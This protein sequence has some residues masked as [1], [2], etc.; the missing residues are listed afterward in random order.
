ML[1]EFSSNGTFYFPVPILIALI[2]KTLLLLPDKQCLVI[3]LSS[4]YTSATI[5]VQ[6]FLYGCTSQAIAMKELK[7][8]TLTS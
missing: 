6:E 2:S 4:N 1:N 8:L 3:S 7:M 5:C